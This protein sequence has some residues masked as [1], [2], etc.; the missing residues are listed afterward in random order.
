MAA[1][2]RGVPDRIYLMSLF[3][4]E[5]TATLGVRRRRTWGCVKSLRRVLWRLTP[6]NNIFQSRGL[7]KI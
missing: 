5:M 6:P 2:K 4:N 3:A 1:S 7:K